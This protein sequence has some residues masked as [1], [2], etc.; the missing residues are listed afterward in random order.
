MF[1]GVR[2]SPRAD[3]A[4]LGASAGAGARA[5]D[6]ASASDSA[7][8]MAEV[9]PQQAQH[10]VAQLE[11]Q[12]GDLRVQLSEAERQART[13]QAMLRSSSGQPPPVAIP[14]ILHQTWKTSEVPSELQIYVDSWREH[15]DFSGRGAESWRHMFW[16]DTSAAAFIAREYPSFYPVYRKYRSGV[17]KADI[18]R[19]LLLYHYGGVYADLDMECLQS[20]EPLLRRHSQHFSCVFGAEPHRHAN[21]QGQRN[22]LICNA[23]MISRPR[24]PFWLAVMKELREQVDGLLDWGS[25]TPVDTTGPVF[26]TR[27][28]EEHPRL[29]DDAIVLPSHVFYPAEDN[30]VKYREI[31]IR[32]PKYNA[33]FAVH[34]WHHLWLER[35][36]DQPLSKRGGGGGGGGGGHGRKKPKPNGG[37]KFSAVAVR[38]EQPLQDVQF[39]FGVPKQPGAQIFEQL[40]AAPR[41]DG[42]AGSTDGNVVGVTL[43]GSQSPD[44]GSR[45]SAISN[46]LL[47]NLASASKLKAEEREDQDKRQKEGQAAAAGA[48]AVRIVPVSVPPDAELNTS[49]ASLFLSGAWKMDSLSGHG[50][51]HA[52]VRYPRV[53]GVGLP[54][55]FLAVRHQPNGKTEWKDTF[56]PQVRSVEKAGPRDGDGEEHESEFGANVARLDVLSNAGWGQELLLS[57]LVIPD[58]DRFNQAYS[59]A[60]ACG[61][62]VVGPSKKSAHGH[63]AEATIA[64]SPPFPASARV[65]VL[66]QTR[67]DTTD[68]H[69]FDD[70]HSAV[71]TGISAT[72]FNVTVVRV[73]RLGEGWG[74]KLELQWLAWVTAEMP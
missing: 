12:V 38:R 40:V 69:H 41:A 31:D 36:E 32:R 17:E 51:T 47:F 3:P 43:V 61:S 20:F 30:D 34:R 11:R 73:D 19:Y 52:H 62:V 15:N 29:F 8:A 5:S 27:L 9:G 26:L 60:V 23:L 14:R 24:H 67:C 55:V 66:V 49:N 59:P 35:K 7:A 58:P 74:Q 18:L 10:R 6:S 72:E 65:Q 22:L 70:V 71:V 28:Y 46:K 4:E 13:A 56:V 42:G 48:G 39:P 44:A 16:N 68:S 54:M 57:Y 1:I 33:T 64:F 25:L 45:S 63:R 2:L 50:T 53:S 37:G 21:N